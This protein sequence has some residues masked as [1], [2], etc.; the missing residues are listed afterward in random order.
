MHEDS[1]TLP[2]S[3]SMPAE[4]KTPAGPPHPGD[5]GS[6][7]AEGKRVAPGGLLPSERAQVPA[8][9]PTLGGIYVGPPVVRRALIYSFWDGVFCNGMVALQET[10]A[11]AAAV[12]LN[13]SAM[14]IAFM[15]SLPLLLGALAQFLVPA[16]ADP[17]KGRKHYVLLGVRL[18]AA[19]LFV[20]AFTGFLP[21][22]IAPWVYAG[23]FVMA[24]VSSNATGLYWVDWMG[25]LV[26][27]SVRGRH[28]AWRGMYLAWMYLAC[29]LLAGT[30][31]RHYTS[32][33]AP[34]A[35]FACVFA[36]A[37]LMRLV[38]YAFLRRQYE[39]AARKARAV[40]SPFKFRPNRDFLTWCVATSAFGAV[41]AMSG[42]FFSVWYL[43]DLHFDYLTLAIALSS[44]VLGSIA[45]L[46]FWGRLTDNYGTAKV[47]WISGLLVTVIPLPYVFFSDPRLIW[48]FNFYSG[49]TWAGYNMANFNHLLAA[50]DKHE[51][52][53]Y[54]AFATL[55]GGIL[56][57]AFTLLGGF[58]ATRLPPLNGY[59]LR[60]LF[61]LS[62]VLRL[63]ICAAFYWKF[64]EYQEV[65]P[66]RSQ[67]VFQEIPGYRVG[68]GLLRNVFRAFR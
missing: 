55:V 58:L 18:Q 9:L 40:F 54:I 7:P 60:S 23:A 67:E 52:S 51:R 68:Q 22:A 3:R 21:P 56:G 17:A 44:T 15:S 31:A 19:F 36:A 57:F 26:P 59:S 1:P 43:R 38:S 50:T 24:S 49:A 61:L 53:H 30:L 14:A 48:L 46:K 62:A 20:A 37:S 65:L 27:G 32:H 47:I 64:R 16:L 42:P 10:F 66:R 34:W 13:A 2:A 8:E 4:G 11:I 5:P 25:D 35:F 28:F 41:S 12:S 39:P 63:G 6:P 33:N 29:A 45:F